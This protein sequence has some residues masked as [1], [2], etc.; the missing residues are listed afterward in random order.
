M[1]RRP[2]NHLI[3]RKRLSL[4]AYLKVNMPV[5]QIAEELGVHVSTVYREIKRGAYVHRN[6]DWTEEVRYAPELAEQKYRDNLKDKG[7]QLKIGKD[8][9]L[10]NYLEKRIADDD[11]TV[12][13]VLGEI[14][15]SGLTFSTSISVNTLYSYIEKGVFL[16]LTLDHLP[17][18]GRLKKKKREVTPAK[19]PRGTSIEKRPIVIGE[20][21]EFGHWEMDCLIGKRGAGKVLLV[22]TERLSRKEIIMIMPNKKAESVV[23]CLNLLERKFGALF[24][25][26]FKSITVDNGPEF[27]DFEGMERSRYGNKQR[28]KIYYCHPYCS[29]ERG[30]NE[31]M[32]REIRRVLPKGSDFRT[33]TPDKVK[34]IE[35]WLNNYPRGVL[36]FDTPENRFNMYVSQLE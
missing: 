24:S 10:A 31:R 34:R 16:R 19:L 13:A 3:Y 26:I 23:R 11:L 1:K 7:P 15:R 32:N 14:K 4:E 30:T 22:L 25:S 17:F 18:E 35:D 9:A 36:D 5:K 8:H 2:F 27:A 33:I 20:R 28:T 29:C 21:K 6:H 12:R